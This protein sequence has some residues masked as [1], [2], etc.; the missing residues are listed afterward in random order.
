MQEML[1]IEGYDKGAK[2]LNDFFE[3]E[4]KKFGTIKRKIHSFSLIPIIQERL[5]VF[6][7]LQEKLLDLMLS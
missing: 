6:R 7:C 4:L 5:K 2:I 3:K 1:G